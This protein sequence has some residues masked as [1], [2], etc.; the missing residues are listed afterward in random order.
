MRVDMFHLTNGHVIWCATPAFSFKIFITL[1]ILLWLKWDAKKAWLCVMV[2]MTKRVINH[3]LPQKRALV[4]T[5]YTVPTK[6][7]LSIN[8]LKGSKCTYGMCINM[9]TTT[10]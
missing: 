7:M 6:C 8:C 2:L 1:L 3:L 5:F 10:L 9:S 4:Y